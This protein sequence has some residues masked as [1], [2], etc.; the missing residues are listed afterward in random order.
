M[1]HNKVKTIMPK[2]YRVHLT[3]DEREIL[4]KLLAS[5]Q[6]QSVFVKRAYILLALDESKESGRLS[7]EEIRQLYQVGQRSIERTRQRFIEEGFQIAVYGKKRTIFKEKKFDGRV[8]AELIAMRCQSPPEGV[9]SWTLRLLAE[10][11][12]ELGIVEQISHE[13]VRQLLKK[14]N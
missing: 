11:L 12:V 8:E 13:S 4:K 1:W 14:T 3:D 9:Q 6:S 10:N 7:D 5:R 2:R